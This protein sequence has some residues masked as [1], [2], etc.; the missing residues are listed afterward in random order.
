MTEDEEFEALEQRL[1]MKE[2]KQ[3]EALRLIQH[4]DEKW[5]EDWDG[6]AIR[7]ELRR[8]HALNQE[9]LEALELALFAHGKMLLSDPPQEAWKTYEVESKARAAIAKAQGASNE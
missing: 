4:M 2:T 6:K 8:L 3:P 9:L 5:Q 1:N 7:A